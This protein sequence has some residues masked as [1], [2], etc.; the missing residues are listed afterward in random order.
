MR[1]GVNVATPSGGPLVDR[2]GRVHTDLRVSITDRCNLRCVYC[3]PEEGVRFGCRDDVLTYEEITRILNVARRLGVRSIRLTG[4]EPLVRKGIV[5]FVRSVRAM[6]FED[7]AMTTNGMELARL[8][9]PLADAGLHRVNVSCDSLRPDRFAAIRR[10]GDLETVLASMAAA[11]LAGLTPVK[12]N[13]VLMMGSNEDEVLDFAA[14]ARSTGRAVRFIEFMP[15]D[16]DQEWSLAKVVPSIQ[17]VNRINEQWPLESVEVTGISPAVRYRFKDGRGE[18]GVIASVTEPF[19]GT[20]DRLR[21]TSDGQL[22]N[23]LFSED[24]VPL[25]ELVRS[26]CKDLAIERSMRRS[27]WLKKTGRGTVD[28]TLLR[29][30]RSM[31]MIGG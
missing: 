10:R 3:M 19:C 27:V 5:E 23:C 28:L 16:G 17:V 8:A 14:F 18:I 15:L 26:G 21:L 6:G 12:V 25:R 1:R 24:E 31:S 22:R 9:Q 30:R 13:V 20:C 4:G 29:P 2:F 7:V 11:E